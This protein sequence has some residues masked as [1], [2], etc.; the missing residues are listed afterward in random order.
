MS[1][2]IPLFPEP[3]FLISRLCF[4]THAFSK[5]TGLKKKLVPRMFNLVMLAHQTEI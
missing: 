1:T 3:M 5:V 4:P 2:Q